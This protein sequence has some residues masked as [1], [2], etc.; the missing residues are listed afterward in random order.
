MTIHYRLLITAAAILVIT[1]TLSQCVQREANEKTK[2]II[3]PNGKVFAGSVT[4]RKCHAAI[5]DSFV[6]TAHYLTSRPASKEFVKGSF[7]ENENVFSFDTSKV[8]ME[9]VGDDMY[10]VAYDA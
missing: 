4:C 8:I 1:I 10:Q 5:Y 2:L 3:H 7:A 6:H 9:Q